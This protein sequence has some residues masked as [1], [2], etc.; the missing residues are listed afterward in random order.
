[1]SEKLLDELGMGALREQE[2]GARVPEIVEADVQESR[3][4]EKGLKRA[5]TEVRRVDEG[6]ALRGED[7]TAGLVERTRPFHL[8]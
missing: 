3:P 8:L 7:K 2:R 5:V 4:L 6:P 1:M